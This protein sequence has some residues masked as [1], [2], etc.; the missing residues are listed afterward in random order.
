MLITFFNPPQ[1]QI[2]LRLSDGT[3]RKQ[4]VVAEMM[5]TGFSMS[6][7]VDST[8]EFVAIDSGGSTP[9][10]LSRVQSFTIEPS[11]GGGMFWHREYELT[12]EKYVRQ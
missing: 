5:G 8:Q 7:F 2:V 1:L 11:Y 6:P 4:R 12:I 3:T 9:V 10:S